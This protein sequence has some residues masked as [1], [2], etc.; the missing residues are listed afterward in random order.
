[1]SDDRLLASLLRLSST[2]SSNHATNPGL[3]C[4]QLD[5]NTFLY[6]HDAIT[7]GSLWKRSN[8]YFAG[9]ILSSIFNFLLIILLGHSGEAYAGAARG[10]HTG[11]A[12]ATG[13]KAFMLASGQRACAG[14][15]DAHL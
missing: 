13:N 6:V 7:H 2:T 14:C 4:W 11:T 10:P 8:T 3:L 9:A 5:T 12:A 1:M 15:V